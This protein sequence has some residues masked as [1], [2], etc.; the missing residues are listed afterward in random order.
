VPD[1]LVVSKSAG[2][3]YPISAVIVSDTIGK[4]LEAQGFTHLSSHQ[5]DP[6]GA[7]AVHAVIDIIE[8]EKLVEHS[9]EMGIY[10]M[11]KLQSLQQKHSLILDVRG[12]GLMIGLELSDQSEP[13]GKSNVAFRMMMLCEGKGLHITYSYFEPVIRFIPPLIISRKEVDEAIVIIDDVLN[14]LERGSADFSKLT[15]QNRRSGP[16]IKRMNEGFSLVRLLRKMRDTTPKQWMKKL[17]TA[18]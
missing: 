8:E 4:K 3:G 1:I 10:F 2:N 15:T 12:R 13:G 17:K 7:A 11:D 16:F 14:I 18:L 6:L 5:N 9:H